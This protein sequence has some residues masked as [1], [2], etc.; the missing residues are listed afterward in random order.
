MRLDARLDSAVFQLTPTRTRCDL[1]IIANGKTEKIATGLLNPFLAHLKAAQDQIDKG[2]Y[3][4]VLKPDLESDA[5]WFTKGTMERFVR[6]VSTPEVLERVSTIESEIL[7]IEN[8]IA[9]QGNDNLGLSTVEGHQMK[10]SGSTEGMKT[11]VDPN[12]EKAI[13]L[14]KPGSQSNPPDSNGSST[15]E[16]NSR[17]QLLRVLE[18]RKMVLQKEQGMAFARAAAAGFDVSNMEHLIPFAESFGASRLKKA[19]FQFME[20]WKKKH[21]TGQWLEVEAAVAMSTRSE[22]SAL[23][24]SGIIFAADYMIQKDHVDA[25]SISGGDMITEND[26]KP[27][28]QIPSDQKVPLGHLHEYFQ[29]QFQ[30]PTYPQ[31]PMHSPPGHIFQPYSTQ[32]MPYYQ[33]HQGSV[34]CFYAPYPLMDDP[35]FNSSHRKVPKRQSMDNKDVQSETG[36]QDDTDQDTSDLEKEGS[37]G[38]KSQRRIGQAGKKKSGV[39]VIRNINY[40]LSKKLGAGEF[41]SESQSA[42]EPEAVEQSKEV[43]SDMRENKHKHKHSSRTSKEEEGRTK[44]EENSDPY[45]ND[46]AVYREEQ[47]SGN[48]QAFQNFLL[49]AEEKSRT[50]DEDMLMGGKGPSSKR[51]QGKGEADPIVSTEKD[52]GVFHDRRTVGFHSANGKANRMKQAASDDRFLI[53]GYRRDSIDNQFR[54]IESA[55]GA[56]RRMSS[57]EFMIYGQEKQFSNESSSDTL[58]DHVGERAGNAVKSSSRNI[59]DESFVLPYRSISWD[60]GSD[61]VAA[62]DMVSEFPSTIQKTQGSYDK[63]KSQLSYEPDNLSMVPVHGLESASVGYNLAMDYDSKI[64]VGNAAKLETSNQEEPSVSTKKESKKSDKKLRATN[65]SV[66]KRRKDA[67]V[68]KGVYSRLNPL[69]EAQKRAEKLRSYKADLQKMKKE[70]EEEEIKRLEALKRER[71]KRIA[72]RRSSFNVTQSPLTPQQTKAR[73]PAKTSP[74]PYKGSKFSDTQ[75]VSSSPLQKLPYR[76]SSVGSNNLQKVIKSSR[77]NGSNHGLTRS[78]SSLPEKKESSRLMQ[79]AKADSLRMKRLSDPKSSY[80]RHSPSVK[81]LAADQAPKRSIADESRKKITAVRQ[82]DKSK[83][84]TLPGLRIRTIKSSSERVGKGTASKN[85]MQ[86]GSGNKASHASDSIKGKLV[87]DKPPG[88]SD[89]NPVIEKTVVLLESHVVSAPVVRQY[90][91]IIGTKGISHGDGLGTG[92]SAMHAPPSPIV[93]GQLED[94][95]EGKSCEQPSSGEGVVPYPSNKPQKFSNST[96]AE[97]PYQAPSARAT[98]LKD[99]VITKS[100]SDGDLPASESEI[101]AMPAESKMKHVSGFENPS[102]GNQTHETHEKPRSKET[103]GFRKLLKFGRKSHSSASGEGNLQSDASSVGGQTVAAASSNDVSRAF[104]LLSPFRSKNSRKK[105]AA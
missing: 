32:G 50:A 90:K 20:L 101:V 73:L 84:A 94:A 40:I 14:Y 78:A 43:H 70:R 96:T 99:P 10:S 69:T 13:I 91:E 9:I 24:A 48:W 11:S 60:L 75:P 71:Q 72:A 16:A 59:T 82:L 7:Q 85:P 29:G 98:S 55:G 31:C 92:F 79:E 12:T 35:R 74:S 103:K 80:T 22:F 88:N 54:K 65:D 66:E 46:N 89:E 68:K 58:I 45:D 8:A 61:S 47:D 64:P 44:S 30:H 19:C 93:T 77:L 25:Q 27:D 2:G 26:G 86:K 95:G 41:E 5:A 52:Y 38:H 18:T 67:L 1:V 62:I 97:K 21:E 33:N 4:I 57:D 83:S 56:Y 23:N 87:N 100:G 63:V 39:V 104:S 105:Q 102:L 51:K 15:Q 37:H 6:F 34:P 36:S 49:R 81:T 17:V 42:S 76:T 3:S 53:S 28:K